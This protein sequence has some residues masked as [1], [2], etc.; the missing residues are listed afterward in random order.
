VRNGGLQ[1]VVV[2]IG[3]GIKRL[4][5]AGINPEVGH[6]R[7]GIGGRVLSIVNVL[8]VAP[9][10]QGWVASPQV[11]V[12]GFDGL[13]S[14]A[15]PGSKVERRCVPFVPTY[16]SSSTQFPPNWRCTV[17]FHCCVVGTIQCRGTARGMTLKA[18]LAGAILAAL[19]EKHA[20]W[21]ELVVNPELPTKPVKM[22]GVGTKVALGAA[23]S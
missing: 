18:L 13:A 9:I 21:V 10:W 17:K 14:A 20:D 5:G 11:M 8:P 22:A 1:S 23:P 2:G 6:S 3:V 19:Q 12:I 7:R 16:P 15:W 4:E